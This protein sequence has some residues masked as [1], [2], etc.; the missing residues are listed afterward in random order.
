MQIH[1]ERRGKYVFL[2]FSSYF[3]TNP[4]QLFLTID[5]RFGVEPEVGG[6][7]RGG[8]RR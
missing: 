4:R 1:R 5:G 2:F 8:S 6:S 7:G 3:L